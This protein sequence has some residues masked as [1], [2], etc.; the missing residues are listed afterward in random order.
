MDDAENLVQLIYCSASADDITDADVNNI[1]EQSR[2]NN[3]ENNITGLLLN[4]AQFY[5][6]LL[7]GDCKAVNDLY[8]K[9]IKDPR[10][11]QIMLLAYTP[12]DRRLFSGW[13][14]KHIP[15]DRVINDII[16]KF[17]NQEGFIHLQK[18]QQSCISYMW[19]VADSK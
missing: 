16:E 4:N 6:Q 7:E 9:I 10:H 11:G 18:F 3:E 5:V 19:D 13:T 15:E 1:L 8:N 12:T 2:K 17:V 14:M